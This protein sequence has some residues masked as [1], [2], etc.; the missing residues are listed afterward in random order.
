MN[1]HPGDR[2]LEDSTS[3]WMA[4]GLV[5]IGL[6][7]IVF[8]VFRSFEPAQRDDAR[9]R[10]QASLAL[11]GSELFDVN[12]S[13]CHG[14]DARGGTAPALATDQFLEMVTEDQ[15]VQLTSLGVP[16]SEMVAYALDNGGPLTA[17]HIRAIAVYLRSLEEGAADNP[18]WRYPLAAEGLTGRDIFILGCARCHGVNLEGTEDA[19]DLGQGSDA[20]EES[21]ARLARRVREGKD[22][23][24]RFGGTLADEQ[25]QLLIEYIRQVQAGG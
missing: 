4:A 13:S 19:P 18:S 20:E 8:P 10:Q 21:D 2:A 24:P 6:F 16:G 11:Q 17:E 3:R 9:E 25:I 5:L 15:I 22:E 23:V 12:C 7:V 14:N 1:D